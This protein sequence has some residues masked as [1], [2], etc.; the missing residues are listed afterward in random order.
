MPAFDGFVSNSNVTLQDHGNSCHVGHAAKPVGLFD[1]PATEWNM[2][3]RGEKGAL[4]AT[5]T[6]VT[7][8]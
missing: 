7:L 2:P 4:K 3:I 1:L 6:D 5:D 8:E